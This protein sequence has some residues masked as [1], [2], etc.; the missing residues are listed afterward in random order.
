MGGV[1]EADD[2]PGLV[3]DG[4]SAALWRDV[5]EDTGLSCVD[6]LGRHDAV[7]V[8]RWRLLDRGDGHGC[9]MTV[10]GVACGIVR[11]DRFAVLLKL[12]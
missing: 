3:G 10:D 1:V 2:L 8:S 7:Y 9:G 4:D 6:D 5:A 12:A 11:D